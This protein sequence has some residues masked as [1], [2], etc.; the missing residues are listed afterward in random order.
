MKK[1][2]A[3]NK[4]PPPPALLHEYFERQ[5]EIAPDHVAIECDGEAWTYG[6]LDQRASQ[7][8]GILQVHGVGRGSLVG[9]CASK[10]CHTFAAILAVLKVGAAYVPLDPKFPLKRV[11]AIIRDASVAVVL[12][13]GSKASQLGELGV[14]IIDPK[15]ASPAAGVLFERPSDLCPSD[16][17]YVI[18]T[19]GSTGTP[20]GVLIEHRH[21]VNFVSSLETVYKIDRCDRI[22]QGFSLAFDASVEEIWA[23]FSLGGTLVAAADEVSRSALDVGNFITANQITYFS[24][25]PSFLA[26]M[27]PD[28]PSLKL[29]VLGGEVCTADLVE[30]WSRPG[31]R[32]LN[33]YGP[34]EA[35]VVATAAEC[36]PGHPVTIG[37]ALPGYRTLV[38]DEALAPVKP[39][40]CGELYLGGQ[41]VARG[42]LN[43]PELTSQR[44]IADPFAD[45]TGPPSSLYRTF[46]LVRL[47]P[48]NS[49]EFVGRCDG[50]VK[51]RGFHVELSEIES[52]LMKCE[53]IVL[54]AARVIDRNGLPE[55]AAYV[56][57]EGAHS[58]FNKR[59][60]IVSL[61]DRL[62]EYMIPKFLDVVAELPTSTS[63]K[64]D[65]GALPAPQLLLSD[66]VRDVVAP[67]TPLEMAIAQEWENVLGASPIS[68]HDDFFRD[69]HGHSLAA[70]KIVS[71]LRKQLKTVGIRVRDVYDNRTVRALASHLQVLGIGAEA[72]EGTADLANASSSFPALPRS[73]FACL[74]LQMFGLLAYYAALTAPVVFAVILVLKL[75]DQEL[76]WTTAGEIATAA[77]FAVWPSWLLLGVAVK[78]L[79]IGRF[80]PGRYPVWGMYYFR[81]WL[82][83]RFQSLTWSQ[84]FVGTPLMSLYYRLMGARVG[85]NCVIGTSI[86]AAYDLIEIGEDTSIGSDTH[87][88]GYRVEDGWL[89]LGNVSIGRNCFIGTHCCLG[90]NVT[91]EQHA[92]LDD[93][94]SL[95]DNITV[96]EDE[97][98]RGSPAKPAT[99]EVPTSTSG[100]PTALGRFTF[101]LIHLS[102]IY[103]MG[104]LLILSAAPAICLIAYS[105]YFKGPLV[106][107]GVAFATVPISLLWYLQIVIA[108]KRLAIGKISPGTYNV[109]SLTYLRY[110]FSAYLL[111]N[112]RQIALPL[113]A[114][115]FMP[116]FLRQLGAKV[117]RSVE[118][119]TIMHIVP[120]LLEIHDG[121]FLADACI[122]GGSRV[123]DGVLELRC[124]KIGKRT[125]VGNSA[126]VPAGLELGNDSLVGVMSIPTSTSGR[127]PDGTRWLGS[128]AFELPQI[129]R[130]H[131][132]GIER[133]FEPGVSLF[134]AR[135]MID[136]IRMLLPGILI[137]ANAVALC[138][139]IVALYDTVPLAYVLLA[140]PAIALLLSGLS[141]IAVAT[142]KSILIGQFHPT[143]KPL[144]STYVWVN[145]LVTGVY[146]TV[147]APALFPM[148]GT[149]LAPFFLRLMGCKC[150]R[151]VFLETT[152]FSE[153]DLVSIGD[154]AA[155]NLG[156]TIQP[157]LFED[158]IMKA[159][160]ISIGENCSV[161][162]MAIVLYDT[163]MQVG[164]TLAPLSVLMKGESLPSLTRWY[165]IP[166]EPIGACSRIEVTLV[167][168]SPSEGTMREKALLEEALNPPPP[169]GPF[170]R[171]PVH[172]GVQGSM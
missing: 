47:R 49:I 32:I 78:W 63:G 26:L 10:S 52:V 53:G 104:Y 115:V 25:V 119:S 72:S 91:M 54:A 92:R 24:T 8:A 43:R 36:H 140:V 50:Q 55:I 2:K 137:M 163:S 105:L 144:W 145:D 154:R 58:S 106:G 136:I 19:S 121:S 114:T 88:L 21:A 151:W 95:P 38:L 103:V 44:F 153:F 84:M 86:C 152:L 141:P 170:S 149:P 23:A 75:I 65:R 37:N 60:M 116:R 97:G 51:I 89:V 17:C 67:T 94:S 85:R 48:D 7:L 160:T 133:T 66:E 69:V 138:I 93:M 124:N 172:D 42:Y 80:R 76:H 1:F 128:P 81:W 41:S 56:V 142:L 112:T 123:H 164:S 13:D 110:W 171:R 5:V 125:F 122:I 61:R 102:L 31:L 83:T 28:L 14:R 79:V 29:L 130:T 70:A 132:F 131:C 71:A 57:L 135:G 22:Y 33:T 46:D 18:Y 157:H 90:L 117:G 98:R 113:Y 107:I 11:E 74:A 82:V 101:G 159:D 148:L 45:R 143:T 161:G 40:E 167:P 9:L 162:N 100:P 155:L 96:P 12:C 39:G 4:R 134:A 6:R 158:R 16:L 109:H 165:G 146:E 147:G 139:A 120:E 30:R 64:L 3:N 129:Q 166:A 118:V 126:L 59:E 150:G 27:E 77:G 99:V 169:Y 156:A 20:K 68:I 73:R 127:M 15:D 168:S 111:N 62:P 87:L 34:T 35:T 108:V